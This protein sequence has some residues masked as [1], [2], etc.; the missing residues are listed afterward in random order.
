MC[1]IRLCVPYDIITTVTDSAGSDKVRYMCWS[2]AHELILMHFFALSDCH[3]GCGQHRPRASQSDQR[4]AAS[5]ALTRGTNEETRVLSLSF[6]L[7]L[8][9]IAAGLLQCECRLDVNLKENCFVSLVFTFRRLR[10]ALCSN[11]TMDNKPVTQHDEEVLAQT[12]CDSACCHVP[13]FF[14]QLACSSFCKLPQGYFRS[15]Q[16]KLHSSVSNPSSCSFWFFFSGPTEC[17]RP[18]SGQQTRCEG[19]A[20]GGGDLPDPHTWVHHHT[21]VACPGLLRP[22]RRRVSLTYTP[23]TLAFWLQ[24]PHVSQPLKEQSTQ[25]S[26]LWCCLSV[27]IDLA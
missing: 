2:G 26:K 23:H 17:R 1:Y 15:F 16:W 12:Q 11:C 13:D 10:H 22:D 6:C 19:L 27:V 7:L 25:K 24:L 21:L 5:D 4:G 3:S 8:D 20:D 9:Q 18:D 14:A